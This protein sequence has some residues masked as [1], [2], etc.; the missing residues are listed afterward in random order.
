MR[1]H[2]WSAVLVGLVGMSAIACSAPAAAPSP[3]QPLAVY[4]DPDHGMD[5]LFE[6]TLRVTDGCVT[7]EPADGDAVTPVFPESDASWDDGTL[8]WKGDEYRD[9][10]RIALGGGLGEADDAY[11]PDGCREYATFLV[12]P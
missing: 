4:P 6:G 1:R 11:I 10:D 5:A 12:S 3:S 7:V 9:G 8:T 2:A